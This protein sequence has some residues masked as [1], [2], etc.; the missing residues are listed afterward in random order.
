MTTVHLLGTYQTGS[1]YHWPCWAE[2]K[3]DGWR[4]LAIC[5]KHGQ[6]VLR[7]REGMDVTE[8]CAPIVR[9]LQRAMPGCVG[10]VLDGE[11]AAPQREQTRTE[12]DNNRLQQTRLYVWDVLPLSDYRDGVCH[13]TCEARRQVLEGL[14]LARAKR[15]VS[16]VKRIQVASPEEFAAYYQGVRGHGWEGAVLKMRGSP[17]A[18]CRDWWYKLKPGEGRL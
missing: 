1:T 10:M 16:V 18:L 12:I 3:I 2:P 5:D 14:G 15:W 4:C 9:A 8:A 7:T 6:W 13:Q 11:L 17:W